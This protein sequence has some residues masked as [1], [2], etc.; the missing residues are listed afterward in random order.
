MHS[1]LS[2]EQAETEFPEARILVPPSTVLGAEVFDEFLDL[3][4]LEP[5]ALGDH[6]DE[7]IGKAFL[8]AKLP[9]SIR[10]DLEVFLAQVHY[11]LAVRSS[12]LLEDSHDQPFAG[13]YRT[14]MLPNNQ[15]DPAARLE[16]LESAIKLVYASTFFEN[17]RAYLAGTPFRM[18]EEHMA[19]VL[20]KIVGRPHESMYYPDISGVARSFNYYPVLEMKAEDG[21]AEIA[22]G[23]GRTV[24]EGEIATR[25]SPARPGLLP[26]FS[27]TASSLENAQRR[28]YA[29][30]LTA[31]DLEAGM[32]EDQNLALL[33]LDAA[34]RH[35]TLQAIGSVFSAENDAIYAGISRP[36]VRLVT[37]SSM[38]ASNRHRLAEILRYLLGLASAGMESPVEIEFAV[39]LEPD[40]GDVPE[41][42]ILQV[43]PM[44]KDP[45]TAVLDRLPDADDERV[46]CRSSNALGSGLIE[47][48]RDIVFVRRDTFDR[49]QTPHIVPE[50]YAI[51]NELF[52]E[53]R[54]FL[55]I[56]P[57]RW[58][59]ADRWLGI[60]VQWAD[61]SMTRTIIETSLS[62]VPI[63]PSEGT[64]FFQNLISFGIGYLHLY[65]D[66]PENWIDYDWLE[67][68]PR[69][70]ET[71]YV[72]WVELDKDLEIA[73]D[74]RSRR[75][76]ILK[77]Q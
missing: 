23:L 47:G 39:N 7:T 40:D 48:I 33:H 14:Y 41:F 5:V 64:H 9:E 42:N 25:F 12:S 60:P 3:N 61:I 17:A 71:Q 57:G 27:S 74:G 10:T 30:D 76:C 15:E 65:E 4:K 59:S 68:Q 26:Q 31:Q 50:I 51:N 29:L 2:R 62:E 36:G 37:F 55:L 45:D 28:F 19:V 56:G 18:E 52:W 72:S 24:V 70:R 6:D 49:G 11:P 69:K 34:E 21:V 67:A 53:G 16:A 43:R 22:L 46:L 75:G 35:G 44:S 63:T 58:G 66:D 13:I 54:N 20:Q 1:I 77:P 73:V 8:R 32:S 38:L